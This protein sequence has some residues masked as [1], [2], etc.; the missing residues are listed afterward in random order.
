MFQVR[1]RACAR[2]AVTHACARAQLPKA[3]LA[4]EYRQAALSHLD[5]N[6]KREALAALNQALR[7]YG[8]C[9]AR[10]APA[11]ALTRPAQ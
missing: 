4:R 9:G 7:N 3:A 10:S 5:K 6:N 8:T 11:H 1:E 2:P